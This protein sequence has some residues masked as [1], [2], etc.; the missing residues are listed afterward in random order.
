V[1]TVKAKQIIYGASHDPEALKAICQAFDQTWAEIAH[2][3]GDDEV[4]VEAARLRLAERGFGNRSRRQHS[5]Y[6][7]AD[8]HWVEANGSRH[9]LPTRRRPLSAPRICIIH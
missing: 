6:R 8:T 4:V 7:S 5:G 2:Q 9:T 1:T 3:F